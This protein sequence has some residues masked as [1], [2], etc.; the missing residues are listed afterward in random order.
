MVASAF[1]GGVVLVFFWLEFC[2][3]V[4]LISDF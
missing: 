2:G 3:W 1:G 4:C